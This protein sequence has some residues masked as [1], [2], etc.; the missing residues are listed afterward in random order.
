MSSSSNL[1]NNLSEG[2]HKIKCKYGHNDKKFETCRIKHKCFDCSLQY[3]EF[4]D[5]L[6]EYKCLC[7]NKI[8]QQQFDEKLKERFFNTYNFFNY[9]NNKFILHFIVAKRCLPL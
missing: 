3:K 5:D 8:Y 9:D 4:K 6:T 2:I 1:A 7:F